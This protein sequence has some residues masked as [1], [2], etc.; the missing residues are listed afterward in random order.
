MILPSKHIKVSES[1]LGLGGYIMRALSN[2]PKTVEDLWT[3]VEKLNQDR[4]FG[5]YHGFDNLVLALDFLFIIQAINITPE[6]F[7]YNEAAKA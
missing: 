7:I 2:E 3:T 1:L 4:K 6:G 5:A